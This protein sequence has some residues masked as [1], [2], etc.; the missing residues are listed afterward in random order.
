MTE[1]DGLVRFGVAMEAPLLR[2]FDALVKERGGTRSEILR[3][4]VRGE[5]GRSQVASG[6]PA[7]AAL[8]V[9][10][11]HHV[12]DLTERLTE[13]QHALG[14]KVRATMHVHLDHDNCLEV[15]ILKGRSDELRRVAE[16]ILATRGVKQG[17]IELVA[18][19]EGEHGHA[20]DHAHGHDHE[21]HD[22]D[23]EHEHEHEPRAPRKPKKRASAA[24]KKTR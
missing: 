9:V 4:L 12:R 14:D 21:H 18:L 15:T 17:G 22:H 8:T 10:Y 11:D 16:R 13:L 19:P 6:A 20:Q 5:V 1:Q 24:K 7:V 2:A 3:D 23:H